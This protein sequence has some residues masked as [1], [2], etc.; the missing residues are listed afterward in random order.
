MNV[1]ESKKYLLDNVEL[2][3]KD[4]ETLQR[5]IREL[6]EALPNIKTMEDMDSF[7]VDFD[8]EQ[9]LEIIEL[10]L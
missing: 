10:F 7:A 4:I 1:E 9:G 6:K 3:E 2:L 8:I 5:N